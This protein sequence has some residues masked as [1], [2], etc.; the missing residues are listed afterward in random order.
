MAPQLSNLLDLL[1]YNP[2]EP[3]LFTSGL[4]LFLFL[5]FTCFYGFMHRAVTL[6][7]VYVTL[8]SLYFYYKTSGIFFLLLMFTAT[9][10]FFIGHFTAEGKPAGVG[11]SERLHQ[12][13][14][15]GLLQVHQL[16]DRHRQ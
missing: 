7:I 3:L 13:R 1:K 2:A 11:G 8:F 14:D 5:G 16:P 6:R 9:S 12:P 4:F 10:D 15:A